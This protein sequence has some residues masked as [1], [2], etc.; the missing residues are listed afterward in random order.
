LLIKFM[1]ND[2]EPQDSLDNDDDDDVA[3]VFAQTLFSITHNK[4]AV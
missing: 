3:V 1:I 2:Y 4:T